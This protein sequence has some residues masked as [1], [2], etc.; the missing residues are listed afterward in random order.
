MFQLPLGVTYL[1]VSRTGFSEL[2][3]SGL[4]KLPLSVICFAKLRS[5]RRLSHPNLCQYVDVVRR[6]PERLLVVTEAYR[7]SLANIA[8]P[9]SDVIWIKCR[10]IECFRALDYLSEH[11]L[12][13]SCLSPFNVMLDARETVKIGG[14]GLFYATHWG[15][16]VDFPVADPIYSAPETFLLSHIAGWNYIK[17]TCVSC[18]LNILSD[19]WSVGLIFFELIHGRHVGNPLH[20]LYHVSNSNGT[21]V[22]G[23]SSVNLFATIQTLLEGLRLS[24]LQ[25]HT[26]PDF[27]HIESSKD[28]E[29]PL[30]SIERLCRQCLN[31]DPSSRPTPL[32]VISQLNNPELLDPEVTLK[33]SEENLTV[34]SPFVDFSQNYIPMDYDLHSKSGHQMMKALEFLS[35]R[36]DIKELYYYWSLTGGNLDTVWRDALFHGTESQSVFAPFEFRARLGPTSP[37]SRISRPPILRLPHFLSM[38]RHEPSGVPYLAERWPTIHGA[39]SYRP[40]SDQ[41][42]LTQES[43][44]SVGQLYFTVQPLLQ[45]VQNVRPISGGTDSISVLRM[46]HDADQDL[47]ENQ[48]ISVK[49][50]DVEYQVRRICL[51]RRLLNGLPVT[52][53]LLRLE[54]RKD[55]PPFLRSQ[56]WSALLGVHRNHRFREQYAKAFYHCPSL[57]A[58]VL[59][60][61]VEPSTLPDCVHGQ[62]DEKAVNQIAVDLPRCHAYDALLASPIGQASLRQVLISTLMLQPGCLEYTQGMDSV[63]AVFLRL[64]YPDE[65]LAAA[66]L[67][68][69]FTT[70]LPSFFATA[71]FT[72]GLKTFF[73]VLLRLFAFH[74]PGL[75]CYLTDIN[76]PLVGLTTGWIYTMF[77][78]AMPLD[79]T[80]LVWDTLVV[81]PSALP[82]FFY[83]AVFLQLD[84]QVHFE[85]V[86]LEKICTILS[87][88][89]DVDLDKCRSDALR[90]SLS[91]PTSLTTINTSYTHT[92]ARH[93]SSS[94]DM[95]T[96]CPNEARES[97]VS[98]QTARDYNR[99]G[100]PNA[101]ACSFYK[102][103]CTPN[104]WP[105]HLEIPVQS[106]CTSS[107]IR[108]PSSLWLTTDGLV[109]LL[110]AEDALEHL[111]R[112]DCFVLDVRRQSEYVKGCIADSVYRPPFELPISSSRTIGDD[113]PIEPTVSSGLLNT[114]WELIDGPSG[115]R[116]TPR[117]VPKFLAGLLAEPAWARATQAR[118]DAVIKQ[119]ANRRTPLGPTWVVQSPGLIVVVGGL[120]SGTQMPVAIQMADW[121]IRHEVD[122]VCALQGGIPALL[123]LPTGKDHV[124]CP[125]LL[126]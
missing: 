52:E 25:K 54:A 31:F 100:A 22:T 39:K 59:G 83:L 125:G 53:H 41:A 51:F 119:S 10:L 87:N 66:C 30:N 88:F 16:D 65:A 48:P 28:F 33:S 15:Q 23:S 124:V 108:E 109:P 42:A 49:E 14:F 35:S 11:H 101:S 115:S 7:K 95:N 1:E 111:V 8:D 12:V 19:V 5:M 26:F 4:P 104:A 91:T 60:V 93:V 120:D 69:F 45:T 118:L 80:E 46:L 117:I 57:L 126:G 40:S 36:T 75:A 90:F 17:S 44:L 114:E 106:F 86:G 123:N 63:A 24:K 105:T 61:D 78:H 82:M 29:E 50:A 97:F 92:M 99:T 79:R 67:H 72:V 76:V 89:P 37:V 58:N 32:T 113:A 27:M 64:C 6:K 55:I 121:L 116:R 71:G 73:N 110:H 38:M 47:V 102:R 56:I 96:S 107:S 20:K 85:S 21:A 13:H 70:K 34:Q 74:L 103:L 77:A 81:G 9:I 18:P 43:G 94:E 112:P 84:Q 2:E 3:L 62:L 98:G 122:H 68:S